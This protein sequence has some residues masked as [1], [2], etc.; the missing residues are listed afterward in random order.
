MRLKTQF[1]VTQFTYYSDLVATSLC[2]FSST[3]FVT[4]SFNYN[5]IY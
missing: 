3:K 2:N 1:Y 4:A 5:C